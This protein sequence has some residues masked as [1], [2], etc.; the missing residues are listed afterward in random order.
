M[1]AKQTPGV[2]N[3]K[4]QQHAHN[5]GRSALEVGKKFTDRQKTADLPAS[6]KLNH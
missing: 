5:V 1:A 6:L 2:S 3:H 4:Y